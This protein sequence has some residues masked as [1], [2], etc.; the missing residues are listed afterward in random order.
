MAETVVGAD[1]A[2]RAQLRLRILTADPEED[3][4][5]VERRAQH[6]QHARSPLERRH[7]LVDLRQV[8]GMALGEQPRGAVDV[9]RLAGG[10]L[11]VGERGRERGSEAPLAAP[12]SSGSASRVAIIRAPTSMPGERLVQVARGPLDEAGVDRRSKLKTRF[13][14]RRSR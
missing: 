7:Q 5:L 13:V 4:A 1:H 11:E 14:P 10:P 9:E 8:R 3:R 6:P 2:H 12:T